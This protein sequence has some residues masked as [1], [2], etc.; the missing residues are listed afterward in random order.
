MNRAIL[1]AGACAV[2]L[3]A[4]A[5]EPGVFADH[6]A[7]AAFV[8]TAISARDFEGLT[9]RLDGA[10]DY[11]PGQL[12]EAVAQLRASFPKDFTGMSLL[13]AE[14]MEGGFVQEARAFWTDESYAFFYALLHR[15]EDGLV[16]VSF[17][18]NSVPD[19]ILSKF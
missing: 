18:L 13:K 11:A 2:P 8:D 9:R 1:F 17:A 16:V 5:E 6:A 7:Y 14:E 19:A 4:A 10:D 3:A 15:K 12:E